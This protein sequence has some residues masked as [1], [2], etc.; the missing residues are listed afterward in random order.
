MQFVQNFTSGI[1]D[2]AGLVHWCLL[3]RTH[4]PFS[5]GHTEAGLCDGIWEKPTTF[6]K[7]IRVWTVKCLCLTSHNM[8]RRC[9]S[10]L[11]HRDFR[12]SEILVAFDST[13][14]CDCFL[15]AEQ[16]LVPGRPVLIEKLSV[17]VPD[18][19][20]RLFS[21]R[22]AAAAHQCYCLSLCGRNHLYLQLWE[23]DG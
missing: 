4:S 14:V 23:D 10:W 1:C 19:G 21:Q 5:I 12:G 7:F 8:M 3:R 11:T 9:P 13:G 22:T 16:L 15:T 20:C 2:G 6:S 18:V 17:L